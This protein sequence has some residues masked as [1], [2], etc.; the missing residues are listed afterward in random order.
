MSKHPLAAIRELGLTPIGRS[1]AIGISRK[2]DG[3]PK[4]VTKWEDAPQKPRKFQDIDAAAPLWNILK[5][6]LDK[7]MQELNQL[8][9][10]TDSP[11]WSIL[12]EQLIQ[13]LNDCTR[14]PVRKNAIFWRMVAMRLYNFRLKRNGRAQISGLCRSIAK[15]IRM[16][17]GDSPSLHSVLR[18]LENLSVQSAQLRPSTLSKRVRR[19]RMK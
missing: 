12:Q 5:G 8:L 19:G 6:R 2:P 1:A 16:L 11:G 18:K 9:S 10:D 4:I 15:N 17:G 14:L 13:L 3:L 7:R